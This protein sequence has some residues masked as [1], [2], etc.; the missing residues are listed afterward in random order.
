MRT[1]VVAGCVQDEEEDEGNKDMDRGQHR[2]DS[3]VYGLK[4]NRKFRVA[5][6]CILV[7]SVYFGWI[8][9]FGLI[10]IFL[11]DPGIFV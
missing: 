6:S 3:P 9:V 1:E 4:P 7:G 10:W 2:Q 8:R 5:H 11:G